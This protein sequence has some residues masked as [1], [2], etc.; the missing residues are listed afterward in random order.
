MMINT[1][2]ILLESRTKYAVEDRHSGQGYRQA[3]VA[4]SY[5]D[6]RHLCGS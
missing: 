5:A 6:T 4:E 3:R 2:I 1:G